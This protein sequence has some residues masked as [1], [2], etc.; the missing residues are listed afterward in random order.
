MG[1]VSI[2]TVVKS[3][4]PDDI[5]AV[6]YAAVGQQPRELE[7]SQ[8]LPFVGNSGALAKDYLAGAGLD[9]DMMFFGHVY[10]TVLPQGDKPS[11]TEVKHGIDRI[12]EELAQ[13][14]NLKAVV[15]FGSYAAKAAFSL[16]GGITRV[17]GSTGTIT[18]SDGREVN[19]LAV[20]HPGY[21]QTQR[22]MRQKQQW[23]ADCRSVVAR[24]MY[25]GKK[26]ELPDIS[27]E[28]PLES[29]FSGSA[30]TDVASGIIGLDT[31]TAEQM[32]KRVDPRADP[33]L[34]TGLSD[35][36]V[37][38]GAPTFSKGAEPIAW[39]MPFDA[40]VIDNWDLP[41][42]DG[43]MLAHLLGEFDTTMKGCATRILGRPMMEY[44]GALRAEAA[45]KIRAGIGIEDE[46]VYRFS[47]YCVQDALAHKDLFD[48][49]Y[50]RASPEIR[51][52]YERVERPMLRLYAKWTSLGVFRLDREAAMRKRDAVD[53]RI[54][55]MRADLM[56]ET[57]V[58]SVHKHAKLAQ[59]LGLPSTAKANVER[60]WRK[61]NARQ[62]KVIT[63]I[64]DLRSAERQVSTYLDSWLEWPE[65][66]L[67]TIW[68]PTAAW[69]G[70][71]GSADLN[72]QNIPG[73]CGKCS[74]CNAN[75]PDDCPLNLK[76]LLLAPEGKVL[77]EADNSQAE[78]RVAA[79]NSQDQAM[80]KAFTEGIL[81]NG[82]RIYD[83]H[84][85][86]R[87]QL[88]INDR[89]QA[90]IAVL[91]TFYGSGT[92]D[93]VI[94][95]T[96]RGIFHGYVR[97]SKKVGRMSVVP[98]L[99]GRQMYV[100]PHPN[101]N[102]RKREAVNA[103]SQGGAVDILKIQSNDLE[104]AGFD[105]RHAIHDS[106]L[107]AVDESEATEDTRRQIVEIME[108]AVKLSVPLK[109]GIG[110]WPQH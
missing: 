56:A 8:G 74:M 86:A 13:F 22:S 36:R 7:G 14:P 20:V 15:L 68:R 58:D 23:D 92:A 2:G 1:Q 108:N 31:E 109:V 101:E 59:A 73:P 96:L 3:T 100:P 77:L 34:I 52:L 37:I 62:R 33:L 16:R 75:Q 110:Q 104:N 55:E 91:A 107:V 30:R 42:H 89:R 18:L 79:H 97:W 63:L 49:L 12:K 98:G 6:E 65:P 40:V 21:V 48:A 82:E 26:L 46:A 38:P 64:G 84:E 54:R 83:L 24:V 51:S 61:L 94:M 4:W 28:A 81:I 70:R 47:A 25:L 99:F 57:G 43:K 10:Q 90:K 35:G 53:G 5:S 103:P 11:A 80:I 19:C 102:H 17:H 39:N 27:W 67:S 29:P 44:D 76:P 93:E 45:T 41:W 9:T 71:P 60:D 32:G 95:T 87:L 88:G 50:R 69:T 66:L 72:L 85:W 106:C 78:L 105:T